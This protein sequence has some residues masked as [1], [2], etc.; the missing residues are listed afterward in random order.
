MARTQGHGNPKWTRDETILA[1]ALYF[2]SSEKILPETDKGV[3]DLS[4]LLR[5]F[6]QHAIVSRRDTFRNSASIA[7]KLQNLRQVATGK[8]LENVSAMDRQVWAELGSDQEEV[9]R[10]AALIRA[11]I[12]IFDRAELDEVE[13]E[14]AEGRVITEAHKRR[15]RDP[16]V[17]AKLLASQ[18]KR[19]ELTCAICSRTSWSSDQ[20]LDEAMFEGHHV[21]P[22]S[23]GGEKKTRL[24]DMALLCA[25][26]H[27]LLHRAI[28]LKKHWVGVGEARRMWGGGAT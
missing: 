11:S 25:N 20:I 3:L 1:L 21:V 26:C 22:L 19:G 4:A 7:F 17:R 15:E 6:P 5:R 9:R 24:K 10:L 23:V 16:S 28:S 8:G 27:R 14:F 2:E 13:D 18:R 12:E